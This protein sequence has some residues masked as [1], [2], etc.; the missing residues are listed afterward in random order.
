MSPNLPARPQKMIPLLDRLARTRV[1]ILDVDGVLTDGRLHITEQGEELK[2]FHSR[3]G[4]GIKLLQKLGVTVAII[5]GRASP[6]IIHRAKGLGIDQVML[7]IKDKGA[8]IE[9]MASRLDV[10][11]T[12]MAVIGDDVIDLPMLARA[13]VAATVADA[14]VLVRARCDWVGQRVGGDAAVREFIDLLIDVR[15][16]WPVVLAGQL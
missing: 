7:G 2:V 13:G 1:L 16:A 12:E 4:H 5:S 6:A 15:D 9:E 3:D 10:P 11:M 14:P 8:A